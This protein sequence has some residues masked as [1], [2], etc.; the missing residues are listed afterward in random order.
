MCHV[1]VCLALR[2]MHALAINWAP[3]LML[4]TDR[5]YLQIIFIDR[6]IH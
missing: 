1:C 2:I 4:L 5:L 3:V 6:L